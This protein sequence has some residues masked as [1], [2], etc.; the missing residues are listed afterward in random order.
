[1]KTRL[2]YK[3]ELLSVKYVLIMLSFIYTITMILSYNDINIDILDN[4]AGS[5]LLTV[6]PM[7][8][9]SYVFKFCK[10]HRMFIHHLVCVNTVDSVDKFIGIPIKDFNLLLLYLILYGVFILLALYYHQRERT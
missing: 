5:S 10:Y 8:I 6:I 2:I 4:I 1:M 9:S 3:L 7:Y